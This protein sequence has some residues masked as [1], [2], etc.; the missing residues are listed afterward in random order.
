MLTQPSDSSLSIRTVEWLRDNGARGIVNKVENFWYT[1][2][3]APSTGGPALHALPAPGRRQR[4]RAP[5]RVT[6]A[7]HYYKPP[8][9]APGDPS[10]P[11]R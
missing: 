2:F 9:I 4:R 8:N 3:Q 10:G 7:V 6:V 5:A 1:T 11:R